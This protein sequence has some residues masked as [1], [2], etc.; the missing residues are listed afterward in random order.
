MTFERK[1]K[2]L[3]DFISSSNGSRNVPVTIGIRNQLHLSYLKE[4]F[5]E[6]KSFLSSGP[7]S[8]QNATDEIKKVHNFSENVEALSYKYI[9]IYENN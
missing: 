6:V 1:N 3:K 8:S 5:T 9:H 7:I 4:S 2:E